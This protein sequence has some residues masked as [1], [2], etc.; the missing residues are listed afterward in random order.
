MSLTIN[1]RI[2]L[3]KK[4]IFEIKS[5]IEDCRS[6]VVGGIVTGILLWESCVLP[7]LLNNCSTWLDIKQ[8]DMDKLIKIQN[9]FLNVLL[10][11][12]NCPAAMMLWDVCLLSIPNRILKEKLMLYHHISCL[13]QGALASQVLACQQ[14][15]ELPGLH[16]EVSNFLKKY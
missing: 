5:I 4:S 3:T 11:L 6:Q 14:R 10:G 9:L 16:Q 8:K 1:K 2:G 15:H 12:R 13:P 7:F